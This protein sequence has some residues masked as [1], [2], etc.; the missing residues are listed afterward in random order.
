MAFEKQQKHLQ[1]LWQELMSDEEVNV[2][3]DG[4][5]DNYSPSSSDESDSDYDIVR[6]KK[7]S[8]VVANNDTQ[9]ASSELPQSSVQDTSS[10]QATF[11]STS[12]VPGTS[13]VPNTS[14]DQTI[15]DVI[16]MWDEEHANDTT[17]IPDLIWAAPTGQNLKTFGFTLPE[18]GFVPELYE[19]YFDKDPYAFYCLFL[20]EDL[21]DLM[22]SFL[23]S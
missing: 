19:N 23:F 8:R 6:P 3:S 21:V 18:H 20:N 2:F 4:S 14:I 11:A 13:F 1:S 10:K 22:V 12:S 7:K 9:A 5:S 16:G 15:E 17:R